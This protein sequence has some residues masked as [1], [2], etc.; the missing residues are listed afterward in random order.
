VLGLLLLF[1]YSGSSCYGAGNRVPSTALKLLWGLLYSRETGHVINL[2]HSLCAT[3][4]NFVIYLLAMRVY[5]LSSEP[6]MLYMDASHPPPR[7]TPKIKCGAG[8][9]L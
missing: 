8:V 4:S 1:F 3:A 9:A 2:F 7:P 6:V 5:D